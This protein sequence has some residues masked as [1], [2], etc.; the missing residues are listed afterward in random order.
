[1]IGKK[2]I[3]ED[4][5]I[6]ERYKRECSMSYKIKDDLNKGKKRL[7]PYI[8]P[9]L[10]RDKSLSLET[11]EKICKQIEKKHPGKIYIILL[12]NPRFFASDRTYVSPNPVRSTQK[13]TSEKYEN[14]PKSQV[15]SNKQ[16]RGIGYIEW[17]D[18]IEL[19]RDDHLTD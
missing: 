11:Y 2:K 18:Y 16:R 6:D 3:N 19:H 12:N 1:M 14:I 10:T 9:N 4:V 15:P 5:V 13:S 7:N 17:K 8:L